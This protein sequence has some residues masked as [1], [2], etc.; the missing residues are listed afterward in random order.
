LL[1][2]GTSGH[3]SS[4]GGTPVLKEG[5]QSK[6]K[7]KVEKKKK[8]KKSKNLGTKSP[9]EGRR[10]VVRHGSRRRRYVIQRWGALAQVQL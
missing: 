9:V 4:G 2:G 10:K 7:K 8:K 5:K 1:G 6:K 3:I